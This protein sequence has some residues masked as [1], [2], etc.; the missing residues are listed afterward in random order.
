[1]NIAFKLWQIYN[2][3][4]LAV[5]LHIFGRA[6]ICP[7][8]QLIR[9]FPPSGDILDVGCGYGILSHLLYNDPAN[10][11]RRLLG[12]DHALNK[13]DI[14]RHHANTDMGFNRDDIKNLPKEKFDTVSI[15]DVLCVISMNKWKSVLD[16]CFNALR[17]GGKLILKDAVDKPRWKFWMA[18]AE[19][20]LAVEIFKITKGEKPHIESTET[21]CNKLEES[22][23]S[24]SE[25]K[26]LKTWNW[27]SHCVFIAHKKK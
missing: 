12:L 16:G 10:K 4:P 9:Y 2:K 26:P 18:M 25:V 24:V 19:E 23:F 6:L 27:Y 1:M 15:V 20:K 7:F 21:F 8:S 22:G 13:I 11:G 14:A 3:A 5:R 17:P